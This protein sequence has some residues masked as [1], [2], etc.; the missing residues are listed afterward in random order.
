MRNYISRVPSRILA[1]ALAVSFAVLS[2]AGADRLSLDPAGFPPTRRGV[3]VFL[4]MTIVGVVCAILIA[5]RYSSK[6]RIAV[7]A[8]LRRVF[9]ITLLSSPWFLILPFPFTVYCVADFRTGLATSGHWS[10]FGGYHLLLG[11]S[12]KFK[13]DSYFCVDYIYAS[14]WRLL[15]LA[16]AAAVFGAFFYFL[17]R[18][19]LSTKVSSSERHRVS[20][21]GGKSS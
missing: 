5:N 3:Y 13:R 4:A 17:W 7:R 11:A 21:E 16:I 8:A 6:S 20:A 2:A 19:I 9:G 14:G 1:A 15:G 12:D 10:W 18:R